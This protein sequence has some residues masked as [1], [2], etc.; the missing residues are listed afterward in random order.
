MAQNILSNRVQ[1][2]D[3]LFP[4]FILNLLFQFFKG[5]TVSCRVYGLPLNK[6]FNQ[7]YDFMDENT[8]AIIKVL[9][10]LME[11]EKS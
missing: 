3:S 10:F 7:N 5:F 11:V 9:N 6:I 8:N 2:A 4:P 1:E